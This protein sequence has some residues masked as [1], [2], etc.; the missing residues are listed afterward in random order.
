MTESLRENNYKPTNRDPTA[1]LEKTTTIRI[2]KLPIDIETQKQ[3]IRR[4]KSFRASKLYGLAKCDKIHRKR[5][6]LTYSEIRKIIGPIYVQARVKN[7]AP[8][9]KFQAFHNKNTKYQNHRNRHSCEP[10]F[11]ITLSQR[12]DHGINGQDNPKR[13]LSNIQQRAVE[14][15]HHSYEFMS[16]FMPSVVAN[17][18]MIYFEE[19]AFRFGQIKINILVPAVQKIFFNLTTR[20]TRIE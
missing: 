16:S 6:K 12:T 4:K 9:Q 20:K 5:S 17:L 10:R 1:Y 2:Q 13:K 18:C 19:E 11:Q 7:G 14:K 8:A 3:L 15:I